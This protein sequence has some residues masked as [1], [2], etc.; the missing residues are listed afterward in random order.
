MRSCAKRAKSCGNEVKR[1]TYLE[2]GYPAASKLRGAI[3]LRYFKENA[4][5]A[6]IASVVASVISAA[7][8]LGCVYMTYYYSTATQDRQVRLEQ[9][10]KFD[11]NSAQLIDAGGQFVAAIN[12]NNKDLNGAKVKMRTVVASQLHD[13]EN[14]RKFF[15]GG[16]NKL[17]TDYQAA[18]SD[19][20]DVAQKTASPME[21]RPWAESFGRALDAK[22]ILSTQLYSSIGRPRAGTS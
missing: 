22:A 1:H 5:N 12:S 17:V 20:N 3:M 13:S 18:I 7:S 8:A 4:Q 11:G 16:I 21:M 2:G 15:D 10:S 19:L 6:L 14:L 9:I